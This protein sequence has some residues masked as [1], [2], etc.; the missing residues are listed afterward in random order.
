MTIFFVFA[1]ISPCNLTYFSW[2]FSRN[3]GEIPIYDIHHYGSE[4]TERFV[5]NLTFS[6]S[7]V[8]F[9]DNQLF[10]GTETIDFQ[11]TFHQI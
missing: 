9:N 5:I 10:V 3:T 1:K 4:C 2:H 8:D 7:R 6:P 11:L